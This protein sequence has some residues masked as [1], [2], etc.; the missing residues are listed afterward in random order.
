MRVLA[1]GDIHG[2]SAGLD[3]VLAAARLRPDETVVT[4]GDYGDRGPDTKGVLDRLLA[5]AETHH[6]VALRGNHDLMML[7]ARDSGSHW[8]DWQQA[9]GDAAV[10]SYGSFAVVPE[11]H[12]R[13]LEERCVAYWETD[14]HFFVHASTYPDMPLEEQPDY[15]LYW[16][17]F[18]DPAP[19]QSG[20]VM[21]CGHTSQ[22]SG[23]PANRGHAVCID[24]W[25]CGDGWLSCL[26]VGSGR[27]WQARQDRDEVRELWLDEFLTP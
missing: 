12:W 3:R 6:L 5:L 11:R 26:D 8:T 20:K 16:G 15:I 14:T 24:T 13:F 2:C 10:T 25:A 27:L 1:I 9:G 7:Q 18:N 19:H 4:L 17:R 23:L 22:K 21:V